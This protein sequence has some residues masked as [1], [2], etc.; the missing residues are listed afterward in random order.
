MSSTLPFGDSTQAKIFV[1]GHD[2]RLQHS[3]AKAETA[4]FMEYLAH[5]KPTYGP[6][7]S[8]YEV[9]FA[10]WEYINF[11]AGRQVALDEI[12]ATNLCNEFLDHE[13]GFGT[14]I[15]YLGTTLPDK[16]R[17]YFRQFAS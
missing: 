3:Q 14:V 5:P 7:K 17:L 2:P 6:D 16:G 11:L 4:F 12:Y 8:K 15:L 10:V 1:I 13:P 9:A